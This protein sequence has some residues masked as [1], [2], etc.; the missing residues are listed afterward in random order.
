MHDPFD[1]P[2]LGRGPVCRKG[3]R[4]GPNDH[5]DEL[6]GRASGEVNRFVE[7][8]DVAVFIYAPDHPNLSATEW[9]RVWD[10]EG[11]GHRTSSTRACCP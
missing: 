1:S 4:P 5:S 10:T 11:Q 6:M 9:Q 2:L 7:H 3:L 8:L